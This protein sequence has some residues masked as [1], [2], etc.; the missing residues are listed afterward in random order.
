MTAAAG[1]GQSML[2]A[3]TPRERENRSGL[4]ADA[5]VVCDVSP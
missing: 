1:K 3:V 5:G 4:P 2:T